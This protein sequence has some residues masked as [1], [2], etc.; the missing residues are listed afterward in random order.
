MAHLCRFVIVAIA[1]T[2]AANVC[3][4]E[5]SQ[6]WRCDRLQGN[7]EYFAGG[8]L[9]SQPDGCNWREGDGA[10]MLGIGK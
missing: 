2:F 4:A 5:P 8:E 1:A 9:K 10:P 7:T 6:Q 3:G